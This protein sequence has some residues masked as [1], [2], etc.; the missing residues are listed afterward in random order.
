MNR[1]EEELQ[2]A[3]QQ[4]A[5]HMAEL[6]QQQA[7]LEGRA[8]SMLQ[9]AQA[10]LSATSALSDTELAAV[11]DRAAAAAEAEALAETS[12]RRAGLL[13][14]AMQRVE[15]EVAAYKAN[16]RVEAF[17]HLAGSLDDD[18]AAA[19]AK[20][21]RHTA[22]LQRL[23][24]A[25]ADK[26]AVLQ[27]LNDE[28]SST[29]QQQLLAAGDACAAAAA[30]AD[31]ASGGACR[32]QLAAL[33]QQV[34]Q[35]QRQLATA[36]SALDEKRAAVAEAGEQLA[37]AKLDLAVCHPRLASLRQQLQE[38]EAAVRAGEAEGQVGE[39]GKEGGGAAAG[40][41]SAV[42]CADVFLHAARL[43]RRTQ[44]RSNARPTCSSPRGAFRSC[45]T[46]RLAARRSW[47]HWTAC[48]ASGRRR[49]ARR[50][51][52]SRGGA[53]SSARWRAA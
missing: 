5:A 17:R 46:R 40:C 43:P 32:E 18:T 45:V 37:A 14:T 19:A 11:H 27:K 49:C 16:R 10:R 20:L 42:V 29:L 33:Q 30:A 6:T 25:V 9:H 51:T 3:K 23:E 50:P 7:E 52:S 21:E 36:D 2:Q 24:V 44:P 38:V 28:L 1:L 13:K 35:V 26:A 31:G 15:Q 22:E 12:A 39:R 8:S 48:T 4:H 41:T 53:A 47:T 34:A